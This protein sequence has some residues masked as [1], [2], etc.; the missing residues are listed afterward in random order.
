MFDYVADEDGSNHVTLKLA[1]ERGFPVIARFNMTFE[2]NTV[3]LK[4]MK[5]MKLK[6]QDIAYCVNRNEAIFY[7]PKSR[8]L[9]AQKWLRSSGIPSFDE[10]VFPLSDYG[11]TY[12]SQ[13]NCLPEKSMF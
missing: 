11:V 12:V 10:Y 2:G 6:S 8:R 1:A 7:S 5:M 9:H 13:F 3:S 4:F